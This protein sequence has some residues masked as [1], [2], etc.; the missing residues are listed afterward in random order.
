MG[1]TGSLLSIKV[2]FK[3]KALRRFSKGC[4]ICVNSIS[5]DNLADMKKRQTSRYGKM[6]NSRVVG[7]MFVANN[8]HFYDVIRIYLL[9]KI[10]YCSFAKSVPRAKCVLRFSIVQQTDCIDELHLKKIFF[11]KF[12]HS[13][14]T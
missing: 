5:I 3:K 14:E 9:F 1:S 8:T 10:C 12:S 11:F 2:F 6:S 4:C 13:F 7:P